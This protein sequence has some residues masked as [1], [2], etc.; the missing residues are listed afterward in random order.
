MSGFIFMYIPEK[1]KWKVENGKAKGGKLQ[2][3]RGRQNGKKSG[4]VLYAN[5]NA[6]VRFND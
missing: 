3:I 1:K 6:N 2:K 5:A 4:F